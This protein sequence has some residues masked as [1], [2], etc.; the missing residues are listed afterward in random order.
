MKAVFSLP[1]TAEK[2]MTKLPNYQ[3]EEKGSVVAGVGPT[4]VGRSPYLDFPVPHPS[5]P[6]FGNL[7]IWSNSLPSSEDR[8]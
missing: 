3:I 8:P 4:P 6:P 5:S 2:G 7:V 1:R